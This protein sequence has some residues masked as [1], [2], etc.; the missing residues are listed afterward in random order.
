MKRFLSVNMYECLGVQDAQSFQYE[1]NLSVNDY[2][3]IMN[4]QIHF[5]EKFHSYF[6]F[7]QSYFH[8]LL[9]KSSLEICEENLK[10]AIFQDPLN[11][12][13]M[14]LLGEVK[15]QKIPYTRDFQNFN[16]FIKFCA[17][18]NNPQMS[19]TSYWYFFEQYLQTKNLD[20]LVQTVNAISAAHKKYHEEAAK[21]YYNRHLVF[22]EMNNEMLAKNDLIKARNLNPS[23]EKTT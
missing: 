10:A 2:I 13:A 8:L 6:H 20:L 5:F 9:A 23:I 3:K 14:E 12:E 21:L 7:E 17:L 19:E 11:Y 15:M 22:Y 4:E 16:D 1:I 18:Q